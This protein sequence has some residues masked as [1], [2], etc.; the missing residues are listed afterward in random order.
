MADAERE[1]E[2]GINRPGRRTANHE[3]DYIILSDPIQADAYFSPFLREQRIRTQING[4]LR[5]VAVIPEADRPA[6][7]ENFLDQVLR[8]KEAILLQDLAKGRFYA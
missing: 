1:L 8:I 6:A 7:I 4:Y 3:V 2:R 5:D